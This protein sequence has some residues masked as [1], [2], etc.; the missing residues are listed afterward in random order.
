MTW[1]QVTHGRRFLVLWAIALSIVLWLGGGHPNAVYGINPLDNKPETADVVLDGKSLFEVTNFGN[2]SAQERA[3]LISSKLANVVDQSVNVS[4]NG[5]TIILLDA[6]GETINNGRLLTVSKNDVRFYNQVNSAEFTAVEL[7]AQWRTEIEDAL[8]TARTQRSPGVV[9]QSVA[10]SL[11]ALLISAIAH[12]WLRRAQKRILANPLQELRRLLKQSESDATQIRSSLLKCSVSIALFCARVMIWCV[13]IGYIINLFPQTRESGYLA[14][15]T[16]RDSL[17]SPV[18]PLGDNAYSIIDLLVLLGAFFGIFLASTLFTNILRSRILDIAGLSAGSR[19]AIAALTRY[20]LIALGSLVILQVWGLDLSSLT[21]LASAL[22]VGIGFGF[23]NIARDFG[24]GLILLFERP[25]QVG[26]FVEVGTFQGTVDR[27]GARSTSIKT[28]DRVSIIVPNSYF[29]ENQV[30]NWSHEN[31]LSRIAIPVGVSYESDPEEVRSLLLKAA[32][33][34]AAVVTHPKPQVFFDGFGDSSLNFFLLIWIVRPEHQLII[35]SDLYFQVF[36]LFKENN[37]TIPFPQR[38]L[39]IRSGHL[40]IE[41]ESSSHALSPT[42][43]NDSTLEN[44]NPADLPEG[45]Y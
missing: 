40:P 9:R 39:H 1:K 36:K 43:L 30:I 10:F 41:V 38:D 16:I 22:G 21:L 8:T 6:T 27:I 3:D 17:F 29:L 23:Q 24:S 5:T 31:P 12:W 4:R 11:G 35:K 14:L 45:R 19:E 34:H 37:I 26:D 7:A 33:K 15:R 2:S 44:I 20:T 28:L 25:V 42:V 13:A 32:D 18:F